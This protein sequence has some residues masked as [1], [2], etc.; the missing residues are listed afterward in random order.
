MAYTTIANKYKQQRDELRKRFEAERT[1]DQT[2]FIDQ[3][4]LLK[5]LIEVQKETSK[6]IQDKIE[7]GQDATSNALNPFTR[8]LQR[9][10]DQVEALQNLPFY[11]LPPEIEDGPQSTPIK[12][13]VV[14]DIDLDKGLNKTQREDLQD[15][16]F[17][18]P[19]V[20]FKNDTVEE[21]LKRIETK[22]RQL[23]QFLGEKSK[24]NEKEKVVYKSQQNT[25]KIIKES[26]LLASKG[27]QRFKK[28]GEGLRKH[29]LVKL[30]RGRGRPKIYP[31]TIFY[32]NPNELCEKLAETIIAKRAGNTGLD[33]HIT[34]MLNEL[35]EHR[36][37]S[38]DKYNTLF[39]NIFPL[40]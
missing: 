16:G 25:L 21:T 40:Y 26:L 11:N 3:T 9:R 5:P 24:K 17:D 2:L 22:N 35:L 33:N 14:T 27:V 6:S 34:S 39:K 30:K 13:A 15:M 31:D 7:A 12:D 4:K 19:S 28:S 36:L 18:L 1:G 38:K 32:A 8:E 23:G 20:I 37:I 10:N 29:N